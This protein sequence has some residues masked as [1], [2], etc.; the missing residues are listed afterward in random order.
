LLGNHVL[1]NIN[2]L[3][4]DFGKYTNYFQDYLK[5]FFSLGIVDSKDYENVFLTIEMVQG[6]H[7]SLINTDLLKLRKDNNFSNKFSKII[8]YMNMNIQALEDL[9]IFEKYLKLIPNE[10]EYLLNILNNNTGEDMKE[11]LQKLKK[12]FY[13]GNHKE[14]AEA[15]ESSRISQW[16]IVISHG[17][18]VEKEYL[19]QNIIK[20]KR[21]ENPEDFSYEKLVRLFNARTKEQENYNKKTTALN[22]FKSY[23][24]THIKP[25]LDFVVKI[26]QT[27]E[28]DETNLNKLSQY[29]EELNNFK[30]LNE[31]SK[32][33]ELKKELKIVTTYEGG[34]DFKKQSIAINDLLKRQ[35]NNKYEQQISM[36]IK[37]L[38]LKYYSVLH[39]LDIYNIS[40]LTDK[41]K[42]KEGNLDTRFNEYAVFFRNELEKLYVALAPK[43][44]SEAIPGLTEQYNGKIDKNNGNLLEV[45][46][47]K[48]FDVI[49]IAKD[50]K[51]VSLDEALDEQFKG[52]IIHLRNLNGDF[53]LH[54][55]INKYLDDQINLVGQLTNLLKIFCKAGPKSKEEMAEKIYKIYPVLSLHADTFNLYNDF[56][57]YKEFEKRLRS[58][59][60][61]LKALYNKEVEFTNNKKL[62]L[63]TISYFN[64]EDKGA[65]E[66]RDRKILIE[67]FDKDGK[68]LAKLEYNVSDY[69]YRKMKEI[70]MKLELIITKCL[71]Y[72][73]NG[74]YAKKDSAHDAKSQEWKEQSTESQELKEYDTIF[75]CKEQSNECGELIYYNVKRDTKFVLPFNE[76][77][78]L[79]Y[80][81]LDSIYY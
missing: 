69:D 56:E 40:D 17:N 13:A 29:N 67:L 47:R 72:F 33:E 64:I 71:L 38:W 66:G 12:A 46:D 37:R 55:G 63:R 60:E 15:L 36:L 81:Y 14:W 43:L 20:Y 54:F 44:N 42:L 78:S 61:R 21:E 9:D 65:L 16:N 10:F 34:F 4:Y 23:L 24:N 52:I 75:K 32:V 50:N 25:V 76:N 68:Y 28:L 39:I 45:I 79:L 80:A 30:N 11:S 6:C 57:L 51:K 22:R 5:L 70:I 48:T 3:T 2:T 1:P 18:L 7:I 53:L 58:G 35:L 41:H 49:T 73:G 27:V 62:L 26:L 19:K 59:L 77:N 74:I 8:S 31:K